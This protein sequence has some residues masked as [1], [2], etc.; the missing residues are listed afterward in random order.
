MFTSLAQEEELH[1]HIN[2]TIFNEFLKYMFTGL[3]QEEE[4]FV[5]T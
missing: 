5:N 4:N 1:K 3:A 2:V